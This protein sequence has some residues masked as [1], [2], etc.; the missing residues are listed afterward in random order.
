MTERTTLCD[1]DNLDILRRHVPS[2]PADLVYL[3][4]VG[5]GS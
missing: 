5:T 2:T 1:G 3:T 4:V